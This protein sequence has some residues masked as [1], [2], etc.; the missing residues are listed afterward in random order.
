MKETKKQIKAQLINEIA[1]KYDKRLAEQVE[2]NN[3]W[4]TM[5]SGLSKTNDELRKENR[6]LKEKNE[7]LE[8]KVKQYEDWVERMQEFCNLPESERQT[9][10]KTYLDEI[11]SKKNANEVLNRLGTMYTS[12]F[13]RLF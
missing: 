13:G 3:R 12:F 6:E 9:A 8:E 4:R 7:E 2:N 1:R 11:E 5:Y 10:F